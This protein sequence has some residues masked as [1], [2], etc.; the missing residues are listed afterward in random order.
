MTTQEL[1]D[2]ISALI[3]QA[4]DSDIPPD[5][6]KALLIDLADDCDAMNS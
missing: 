1:A 6:I 2:A 4:L 5:A 3:I